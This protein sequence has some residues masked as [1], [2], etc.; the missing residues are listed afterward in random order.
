MKHLKHLKLSS[1]KTPLTVEETVDGQLD[2]F[3]QTRRHEPG[4]TTRFQG[5]STGTVRSP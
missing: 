2:D 4:V 1:S 3:Q 5:P